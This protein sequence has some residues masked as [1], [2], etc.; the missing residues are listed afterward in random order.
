M[1][2]GNKGTALLVYQG[3]QDP[4]TADLSPGRQQT[5]EEYKE[6]YLGA[7]DKEEEENMVQASWG[8]YHPFSN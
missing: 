2:P 7:V 8:R 5:G 3:L 4:F 6:T 1:V